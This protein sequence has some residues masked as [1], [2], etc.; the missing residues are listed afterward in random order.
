MLVCPLASVLLAGACSADERASQ[1]PASAP[2]A[3]AMSAVIPPPE[4]VERARDE[5]PLPFYADAAFTPHWV[6]PGGAE[7]DEF[8]TVAPFELTNQD[9]DLVTQETFDQKIYVTDFF[10]STC[11]GICKAMTRNMADLQ[12]TFADDPDVLFL[13]HSVTPDVDD[14]EQLAGYAR[15]NGVRSGKWHLVTGDRELIYRLGRRS[16]FVDENQGEEVGADQFLHTE[17]F[18][19]VDR[20]RHIRGIYNGL[21]K[22]SLGQLVA[23]VKRLKQEG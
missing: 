7:L 14:V 20:H 6:S 8:H 3:G 13:S 18:V 17:N 10:F 2:A 12:E 21:N 11:P 22:A 16:Y 4:F 15:A 19:L 5:G 23:D 1:D 9:G